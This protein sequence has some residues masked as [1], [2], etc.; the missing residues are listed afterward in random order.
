MAFGHSQMLSAKDSGR[1]VK[2]FEGV[3]FANEFPGADWCAQVNNA[4][5]DAGMTGGMVRYASAPL[6]TCSANI[7]LKAPITLQLDFSATFALGTHNIQLASDYATLKASPGAKLSYVGSDFMVVVGTSGGN[8]YHNHVDG[9]TASLTADTAK[10][11][12][13]L[14]THEFNGK[15]SYIE[16]NAGSGTNATQC[17]QVDGGTVDSIFNDFQNLTCN[18]VKTG[19]TVTSTSPNVV[20]TLMFDN[21]R[22]FGDHLSGSKGVTLLNNNGETAIFRGGNMEA[23]NYGVYANVGTPG[24]EAHNATFDGMRFEGN[25]T[26]LYLGQY[27]VGFTF[28]NCFGLN[29]ISDNHV[30]GFGNHNFINNVSTTSGWTP[31]PTAFAGGVGP[32]IYKGPDTGYVRLGQVIAATGAVRLDLTSNLTLVRGHWNLDDTSKAGWGWS[33]GNDHVQLYRA[34]PGTNPVSP[35]VVADWDSTGYNQNASLAGTGDRAVCV[36]ADG[37][38]YASTGTACP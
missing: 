16:G 7:V 4:V 23:L 10:G 28:A 15:D 31:W 27:E 26:D 11:L 22:V 19:V 12:K 32:V 17:V 14:Q 3:R 20:T 30:A 25:T 2:W 5:T 24:Y 29:T 13:L 1:I 9:L 6:G 34:A 36:H 35:V 33:V 37:T 8:Q 21:L 38:I 18:H